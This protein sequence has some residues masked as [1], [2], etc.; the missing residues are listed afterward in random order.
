MGNVTSAFT[1]TQLNA[2]HCLLIPKRGVLW[3]QRRRKKH[4]DILT[5][6]NLGILEALEVADHI[7]LV[8]VSLRCLTP[9]M[10]T[11]SFWML[12]H[13]RFKIMPADPQTNITSC[14]HGYEHHMCISSS[15]KFPVQ[16]SLLMPY[17]LVSATTDTNLIYPRRCYW[18][19]SV[20]SPSS[21]LEIF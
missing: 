19:C 12:E 8:L 6:W 7:R 11:Q 17:M 18:W 1:F 13:E 4:P 10:V 20:P 5:S 9:A 2:R 14:H 21:W 3:M 15:K 16:P